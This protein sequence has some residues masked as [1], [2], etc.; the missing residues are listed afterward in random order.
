MSFATTGIKKIKDKLETGPC[1]IAQLGSLLLPEE[2]PSGKLRE[3]LKAAGIIT[4]PGRDRTEVYALLPGH[5]EKLAD[6]KSREN[7]GT[8]S[9]RYRLAVCVAFTRKI[10][11]GEAMYLVTSPKVRYVIVP[12]GN[13]P[14]A[15]ALLVEEEYRMPGVNLSSYNAKQEDN[16]RFVANLH[17]WCDKNNIPEE[18]MLFIPN[19]GKKQS[20]KIDIAKILRDFIE[21]QPVDIRARINIP[22]SI[23]QLLLSHE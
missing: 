21:A 14:P 13:S 10:E 20:V 9:S 4:Q 22:G 11:P 18:L 8:V 23:I 15:S 3:A 17:T 2:K 5:E 6:I 16:Q 12:A 1:L 19:T 7:T